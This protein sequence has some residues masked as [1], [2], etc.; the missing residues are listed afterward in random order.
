[1]SEYN[2]LKLFEG[3]DASQI[4]EMRSRIMPTLEQVRADITAGATSET[5]QKGKNDMTEETFQ[6]TDDEI[7]LIRATRAQKGADNDEQSIIDKGTEQIKQQIEEHRQ[8]KA[9]DQL[10]ASYEGERNKLAAAQNGRTNE[11]Y[12]RQLTELRTKYRTLGLKGV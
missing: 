6:L 9:Q 10:Q 11:G 2:I 5:Y 1:M 4:K 3:L 12:L 8:G 7:A